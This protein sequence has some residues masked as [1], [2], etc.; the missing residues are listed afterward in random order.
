M[1]LMPK[2]DKGQDCGDFDQ[3]H[4]VVGAGGLADAEH[5]DDGE[6]TDYDDEGGD[7]EAGV[8][9]GG[10]DVFAGQVLQA[11][12]QVGGGEPFGVE[13]DAEPV[14]QVDE[15]RG[16]ADGDAHV[17]KGVLEDEVPADD[18]GDEL[19]Q[20]GV[21]VG[22]GGAGDGDHAGELSVAKAL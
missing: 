3:H 13:V 5:Q 11:Q 7:I 15:V 6:E 14:E 10:V 1:K 19:A 16:E 4:D 2:K 21:G 18:P 20:H 9:A 12:R 22:V 8:P 17:G